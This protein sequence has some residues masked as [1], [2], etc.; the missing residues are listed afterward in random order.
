MAVEFFPY[1]FDKRFA[2]MWLPFGARPGRDGVH[3]GDDRLRATFGFLRL[4]TALDNVAGGHVTEGYRWWTAVGPRQSF[5]DDGLTFGTN[6][7]RGVCIHFHERVRAT[8]SVRAHSAL[9]VTVDDC[10]GL[11]DAIGRD[12]PPPPDGEA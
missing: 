8:L 1:R 9:T 10:D 11:L 5:A 12:E 3:V 4:D 6:H 7:D 2:A